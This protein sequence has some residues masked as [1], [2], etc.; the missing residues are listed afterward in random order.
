[1]S[2]ESTAGGSRP[3]PKIMLKTSSRTNMSPLAAPTLA[4]S[5]ALN[6]NLPFRAVDHPRLGW[7]DVI[8][9]TRAPRN[10][11]LGRDPIHLGGAICGKP[12]SARLSSHARHAPS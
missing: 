11:G 1:M 2:P 12:P 8:L 6:S 3:G 5:S 7:F 10:Q 9:L 4:Q